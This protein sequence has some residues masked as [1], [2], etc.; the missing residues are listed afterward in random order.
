M[1]EIGE[2]LIGFE[3]CKDILL[4]ILIFCL[5]VF[6]LLFFLG[7]RWL[8]CVI[9]Y[10]IKNMVIMMKEIEESGVFKKVFI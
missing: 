2:F 9:M 3:I 7:G 6:I 10:F 4:L 8:L 5:F 1:F